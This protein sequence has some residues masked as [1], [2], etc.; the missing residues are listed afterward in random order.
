[1]MLATLSL[2][3]C[4]HFEPSETNMQAAF[5]HYLVPR[6]GAGAQIEFLA[7]T[8]CTHQSK[9]RGYF[10]RFQLSTNTPLPPTNQGLFYWKHG[11][12]QVDPSYDPKAPS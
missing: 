3:G 2:A 9:P 12:W 6:Y 8:K 10:C 7:K 1:M 5:L 11:G 4:G